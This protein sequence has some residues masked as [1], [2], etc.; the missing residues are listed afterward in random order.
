MNHAGQSH[1]ALKGMTDPAEPGMSAE[2]A[3]HWRSMGQSLA[4]AGILL[5]QAVAGAE[6]CWTGLAADGMRYR[7]GQVVDW[8]VKSSDN[9]AVASSALQAQSTAVGEARRGCRS[10]CRTTRRG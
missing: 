7:P 4:Q 9:F 1:E 2:I 3:A 10:R 5:Q 6:S 8:A